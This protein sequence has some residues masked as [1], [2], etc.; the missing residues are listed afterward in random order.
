MTNYPLSRR[1]FVAAVPAAAATLAA[2]KPLEATT[3][4]VEKP[5][6][7]FPFAGEPLGQPPVRQATGGLLD[8]RLRMMRASNQVSGQRLPEGRTYEGLLTGPTLE[9]DPGDT[10]KV[11]MINALA[12]P[13]QGCDDHH[14]CQ[15]HTNLHTH[16]LH[17][18]PSG[19]ADNVLVDIPPGEEFHNEIP[20]PEDHPPG[21]HW[22]HPHR[23]GMVAKQVM[24]GMSGALIIRGGLDEVP[25]IRA[26]TDH[27]M[28]MQQYMIPGGH[29]QNLLPVT[30]NGQ[31]NPKMM[32]M[33]GEVLRWRFVHATTIDFIELQL[34]GPGGRVE[35]LHVIAEDGITTGRIDGRK[36]HFMNPGNRAEIL[37]RPE[38]PGEYQLVA[39]GQAMGL[40]DFPI[41]EQQLATLVVA[42]PARNM[43]LP[44]SS[45]LASLAPY[46]SI[47]DEELTG[48]QPDL[49]FKGTSGAV[50]IDGK[51]FEPGR[52]DRTM[53]VGD[54]EEWTLYAATGSH[55]FHIH[56]NPF[57]VMKI[58]GKPIEE[59]LWRDVVLVRNTYEQGV[60]IRTRYRRFTGLT[61]LHCHN[62]VHEDK[63]MMQLVEL[64]P[65][66]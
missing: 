55:P 27:V 3:D 2:A 59:P 34:R 8:T 22:Y 14:H 1:Q 33:P 44:E 29:F 15:D 10:L 49:T 25:E 32:S 60:T 21:L 61:V 4:A 11:Q 64:L 48:R 17:V 62:L 41:P 7:A 50:T 58:N 6:W 65:P 47:S 20:I 24:E 51:A 9:L 63:G 19:R 39:V 54:V 57:Q 66:R 43:A 5:R 31:L 36:T 12:P 26:A 30:I 56:V 35:P 23:H 16:G 42:G 53:H 37:V 45:D 40:R 46:A 28:V 18:S 52:V 38:E 13:A